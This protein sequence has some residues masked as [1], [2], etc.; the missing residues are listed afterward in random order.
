MGVWIMARRWR[1]FTPAYFKSARGHQDSSAKE[2]AL[3]GTITHSGLTVSGDLILV[4][5][6]WGQ[7]VEP[8]H[9]R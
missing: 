5:R 9:R 2:D 6:G 8:C 4:G 7:F 3:S 1:A